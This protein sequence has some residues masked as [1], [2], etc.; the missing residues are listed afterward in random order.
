[1]GI[2][3]IPGMPARQ[4]TADAFEGM[5]GLPARPT[6]SAIADAAAWPVGG[7]TGAAAR[8][9]PPLPSSEDGPPRSAIPL[10]AAWIAT[11]LF[12]AGGILGLLLF[13][14]QVVAAWPPAER[15]YVALG[16]RAGG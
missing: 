13:Q 5:G 10:V 9:L 12:V 6:G 4:P 2:P 16:V 8:P 3:P 15:L 1:M 7:P 11:I 14:E